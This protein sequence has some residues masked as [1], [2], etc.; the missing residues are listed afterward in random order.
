MSIKDDK[1]LDLFNRLVKS[2]LAL[3]KIHEYNLCQD[4]EEGVQIIR[5]RLLEDEARRSVIPKPPLNISIKETFIQRLERSRAFMVAWAV[6]LFMVVFYIGVISAPAFEPTTA[7]PIIT[8]EEF[9]EM[10]EQCPN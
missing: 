1:P 7:V 9:Q 3:Q 2:I 6:M 4:F 10:A 8:V 5:A